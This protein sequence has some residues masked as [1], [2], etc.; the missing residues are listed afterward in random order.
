MSN[1]ST[2]GYLVFESA[3]VLLFSVCRFCLRRT[4][5]VSK[6]TNG[7]FLRVTQKCSNCRRKFVWDSQSFI[8]C[9]PAGNLLTSAA[10]LYAGAMPTKA[11]RIFRILNC[12]TITLR[13]FFRHQKRY[14][15]P[16]VSTIWEREQLSL[17]SSLKEQKKQLALSGDGRADSPGHSAK[18]GS[19][20]VVDMRCNKVVDY[21]LVQVCSN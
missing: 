13:T 7:S 11:I 6:V 16:A 8:G 21:R 19:Y 17:L 12:A 2:A 18:F 20:T 5:D 4:V 14:L 15:Q 1:S 10:I 3:L 9:V